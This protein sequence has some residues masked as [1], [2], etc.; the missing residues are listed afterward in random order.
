MSW[1]RSAIDSV[2][3]PP[4]HDLQLDPS[5]DTFYMLNS[6]VCYMCICSKVSAICCNTFFRRLNLYILYSDDLSGNRTKKW[7]CLNA[8][9]LM[10]AGFPKQLNAQHDNIHLM[11]V[12]NKVPVLQM[13]KPIVDDLLVLEKGVSRYA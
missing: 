4:S 9:C 7:N 3:S 8:W 11:C 6:N 5:T 12:S 13:V 1:S 10:L 2:V